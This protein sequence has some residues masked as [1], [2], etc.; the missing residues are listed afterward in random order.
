MPQ[1]DFRDFVLSAYGASRVADTDDGKDI[2]G[3]RNRLPIWVGA[4]DLTA[5][6]T[7]ADVR[8]FANAIRRTTEYQQAH[9]R[10]GVML[11]WGFH[12]D[13]VQ[14]AEQL[15][16]QEDIDV[17]FVRLK[18]IRIG[19]AEFREHIVGRSTDR[20]DYSEFL[21][22]VQP[23]NVEVAYRARDN[24]TV[25]FDAGDSIVV[26]PG[27][28]IINVQWDFNYNG[29]RFTATQGH[30]FEREGRGQKRKP[31]L[32]VTHKFDRA[33]KFSVACRVQ[34]S[35]GGEGMWS[36]VVEVR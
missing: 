7:A 13:A 11:A 19:D 12:P 6:T 27:A 3:W 20:A 30:S 33:G 5:Q 21:T 4:P 22:F 25:T 15:R 2:H 9:L 24:K 26:N 17:N 31:K 10:D 29:L 35:R 1:A 36:G 18:Q 8:D 14:A 34:D 32:R 23:P 16:Q 28:E